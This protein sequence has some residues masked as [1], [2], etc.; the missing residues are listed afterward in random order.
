MPTNPQIMHKLAVY[1]TCEKLGDLSMR[2]DP[3]TWDATPLFFRLKL[4]DLSMRLRFHRLSFIIQSRMRLRLRL[5]II[6]G[7]T[8]LRLR[9]RIIQVLALAAS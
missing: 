3:Y 5:R 4:G 6:Q 1:K 8:S 2:R 7:V 9:P